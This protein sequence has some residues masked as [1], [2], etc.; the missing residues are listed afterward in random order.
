MKTIYIEGDSTTFGMQDLEMGGW[1]NRLH[2]TML[3]K[4]VEFADMTMVQN[5]ALPGRT[6]P[7]VL[8]E[9]DANMKYYRRFS[10]VTAVLQTGMNEVKIFSGSTTPLILAKRFGELATK[11]CTTA[12]DNACATVLVGPP[13]IDTSRNNPTFSGAAIKDELLA[14]YGD[15]LRG[16]A[17]EQNVPYVD[18]RAIF[19]ET[20]RPTLELLSADGYHPNAV[21]HAALAAAVEAALPL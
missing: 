21:G 19:A 18:T 17:R 13:P 10:D 1:P 16:V 20:G 3:N 14:E 8:R 11:F 5:R 4:D 6:L 2:V 9:A 7:G 15:I 12:Q